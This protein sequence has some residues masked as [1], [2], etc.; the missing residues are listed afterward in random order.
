MQNLSFLH[1]QYDFTPC[2]VVW[3]RRAFT[4][5]IISVITIPLVSC[6]GSLAL[7]RHRHGA[8]QE[9]QTRITSLIT[10]H[11]TM[12]TCFQALTPFPVVHTTASSV[13]YCLSLYFCRLPFLW[14][15]ALVIRCPWFIVCSFVLGKKWGLC[16]TQH[17]F[18]FL[19]SFLYSSCFDL[20]III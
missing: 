15:K 11:C 8:H 5:L 1:P 9:T 2:V 18:S 14:S 13:L 6:L 4:A 3:V 20:K 17:I 7:L 10:P 12:G 19:I 16:L